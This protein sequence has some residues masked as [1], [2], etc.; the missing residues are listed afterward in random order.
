MVGSWV[1]DLER[2]AQVTRWWSDGGG[3]VACGGALLPSP[4]D[5]QRGI[6]MGADA[7]QA[8]R[9]GYT[10]GALEQLRKAAALAPEEAA[11]R[12]ALREVERRAARH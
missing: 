5:R 6:T 3:S 12:W 4:G 9:T 7:Q 8:L 2:A 11:L 1:L 10:K